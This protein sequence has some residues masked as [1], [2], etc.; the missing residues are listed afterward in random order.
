LA[1]L[2]RTPKTPDPD[3]LFRYHKAKDGVDVLVSI[4]VRSVA[5]IALIALAWYLTLTLGVE[6]MAELLVPM[7]RLFSQ[8]F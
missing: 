5:I 2:N 7:F 6:A 4:P 3:P 8:I 1:I